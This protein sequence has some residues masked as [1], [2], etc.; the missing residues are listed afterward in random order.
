MAMEMERAVAG[1]GEGERGNIIL[2]VP[3]PS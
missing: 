3:E 2:L 1:E